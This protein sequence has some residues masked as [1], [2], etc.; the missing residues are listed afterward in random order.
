MFIMKVV[1]IFRPTTEPKAWSSNELDLSQ[2][3]E[4]YSMPLLKTGN[5]VDFHS[6]PINQV[7][8]VEIIWFKIK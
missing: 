3:E 5:R 6:C 2:P 1:Y 8:F 7:N 4:I